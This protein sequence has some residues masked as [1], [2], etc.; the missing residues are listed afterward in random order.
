MQETPEEIRS[1]A[2]ANKVAEETSVPAAQAKAE[3]AAQGTNG[4]PVKALEDQLA[5]AQKQAAEYL[6]GMQRERAE[7]LNFRKRADKERAEAYQLATLDVLAKFLPVLDDFDLAI[8]TI[9]TE[10][11]EDEVFKGFQ[12]IHRKFNLLLDSAGLKVINPVGE[13]FNPAFHEALGEDA[14]SDK[15]AGTVTVVLRKGYVHGERVLRPAL[16]RVAG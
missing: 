1:E 9:P 15:P 2:A 10:R 14:G 5:E 6:A 11:A 7:F 12:L 8:S 16:V 3:A 13:P 4:A